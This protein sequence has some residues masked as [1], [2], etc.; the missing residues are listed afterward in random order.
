MKKNSTLSCTPYRSLEL[1]NRV[2]IINFTFE[3]SI[4]VEVV[5]YRLDVAFG[6]PHMEQ[7]RGFD[8]MRNDQGVIRFCSAKIDTTAVSLYL[9]SLN[10]V[11]NFF[12]KP[13]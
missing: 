6:T 10:S 12:H 5:T 2:D 7:L 11:F 4:R 1:W 13:K 8:E 9:S 3:R